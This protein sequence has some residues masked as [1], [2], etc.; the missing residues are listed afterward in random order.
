M[1][2]LLHYDPSGIYSISEEF[3]SRIMFA[4]FDSKE[5][6]YF[7]EEGSIDELEK[8]I[9]REVPNVLLIHPGVKNQAR[10]IEDY[11][12]MFP[13]LKIGLISFIPEDY[14]TNNQIRIL[15]YERIDEVL[16]F[17]LSNP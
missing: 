13:N 8:V 9:L 10:V 5:F 4:G 3:M 16:Q 6:R 1:I 14:Q 12:I 2:K 7:A 15:S 17:I 11:P